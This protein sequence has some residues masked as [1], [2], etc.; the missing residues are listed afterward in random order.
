M[1]DEILL[2]PVSF[3]CHNFLSEGR[4]KVVT[5]VVSPITVEKTKGRW[6]ISYACNRGPFCEAV[7]ACIYAKKEKKEE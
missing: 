5:V 2:H 4:E 6:H 7:G 3:G 1:A